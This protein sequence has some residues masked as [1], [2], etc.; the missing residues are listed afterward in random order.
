MNETLDP[1]EWLHASFH[2]VY[3][4]QMKR[5][6]QE[7]NRYYAIHPQNIFDYLY[8]ENAFSPAALS[9]AEFYYTLNEVATSKTGYAKMIGLFREFGGDFGGQK[10]PGF[11]P[12]TLMMIISNNMQKWRYALVQRICLQPVRQNDMAWMKSMERKICEAFEELGHAIEISVDI[13]K[14]RLDTGR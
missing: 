7:N 13:L 8:A 1:S 5:I 2:K 14:K 6:K 4:Q 3:P 9:A 11:C 12:N 10:I